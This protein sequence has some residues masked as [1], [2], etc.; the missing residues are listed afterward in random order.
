[1]S[2]V[3]VVVVFDIAHGQDIELVLTTSASD[4]DGEQD[5]P[6]DDAANEAAQNRD[7]E[8]SEE[9]IAI[10]RRVSQHISIGQL[11]QGRKPVEDAVWKSGAALS[12]RMLVEA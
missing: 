12:G 7:A 1:M 11:E 4:I 9:Q 10:E 8:E 2:E 5:G 6:C 3:A